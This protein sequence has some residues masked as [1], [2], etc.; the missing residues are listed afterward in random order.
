[1][2][3]H[4]KLHAITAALVILLVILMGL[5]LYTNQVNRMFNTLTLKTM[6]EFAG[7]DKGFVENTLDRSLN[8]LSR[9]GNRLGLGRPHTVQAVQ[10]QLNREFEAGS[11]KYLFLI[12]DQGYMYSGTYL[13]QDGRAY[14]YVQQLL[15]GGGRSVLRYD[16][17]NRVDTQQETIVYALPLDNFEVEGIRFIG[18]V[19]QTPLADV[20]E[21]MNIYSFSGQ[22]ASMVTDTKGYYIVNKSDKNGIGRHESILDDLRHVQF[23]DD[24]TLEQVQEHMKKGDDFECTYSREG[25]RY[26]LSMTRMDI[27]DWYLAVTV[28]V[29]VFMNQSRHFI[30]LTTALLGLII[31]VI[32][33]LLLSVFKTWKTSVQ[34]RASARAKADF[35]SKMSHE[36]RTPLNAIIGLDHLM[37]QHLDDK[38]RVKEYLEKSEGT[39]QYLLSLINDIL[40]ISKLNQESLHLVMADFSIPAMNELLQLMVRDKM[41]EKHLTFTVRE[42]LLHPVITGDEMR[43]KQVLLNILSNAVKF[44]PSGGRVDMT[45]SQREE[46]PDRVWT[47]ITIKDTG[48]GMSEAFQKHIFEA[49]SQEKNEENHYVVEG[50]VRGT[51]L[52]MAISYLLMQQMGGNL[53]VESTLGQGSC[54][55]LTL[56][57][58]IAL[59]AVSCEGE[60]SR[61]AV[62]D[63]LDRTATILIAEDNELNARI[64]QEILQEKGHTAVIAG[65]GREAVTA[66]RLSLPGTFDLILMDVQMPVLDGYGAARAIRAMDR[67]DAGTVRIWACTANTAQE[68]RD[69]AKESGMDGFVAK[70]VDFAMLLRDIQEALQAVKKKE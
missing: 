54:F 14:P 70:P 23:L 24:C 34:A 49:F 44:T 5:I 66:F 63:R 47:S 40:D 51:G 60:V 61:T 27:A 57:A 35:L 31:L 17:Y 6:Q 29:S 22:G 11:F 69:M 41:K 19:G 65:N 53:Q 42:D 13:I 7:H 68:N 8:S 59:E 38:D 45:Y 50:G 21:H 55:T 30:V 28:P 2:N 3:R 10:D 37:R 25:E 20:R 64:L 39:S 58:R 16:D 1:M 33:V 32:A 52:G 15:E 18:I 26:V 12:D 62:L 36:I 56:P 48:I 4:K 9:I 46:G 67:A 43:L